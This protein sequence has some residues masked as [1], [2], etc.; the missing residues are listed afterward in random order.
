MDSK[1]YQMYHRL[2]GSLA[3]VIATLDLPERTTILNI[4]EIFRTLTTDLD[5][6]RRTP[7][8][9]SV[10]S[11]PDMAAMVWQRLVAMHALL[12]LPNYTAKALEFG[13]EHPHSATSNFLVYEL[14][15]VLSL[16]YGQLYLFPVVSKKKNMA[17]KLLSRIWPLLDASIS[18]LHD[19][20][21]LSVRQPNFFLWAVTMSLLCAYEDLDSTGEWTSMQRISPFVLHT[22]IEPLAESWPKIVDILET[23]L[24]PAL[25]C[26]ITGQEA[27][28]QVCVLLSTSKQADHHISPMVIRARERGPN[29][30]DLVHAE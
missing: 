13:L 18:A 10:L 27:W 9:E 5:Q 3:P 15:R 23:F 14:C 26:N 24:W 17:R 28:Q 2:T 22:R 29:L 16:M 1:S 8:A 30:K 7:K 21:T 4:I 12:N 25:D 19:G 11:A 20:H 6:L